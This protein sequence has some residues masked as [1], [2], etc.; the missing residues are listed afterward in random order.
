[1]NSTGQKIR[2]HRTCLTHSSHSIQAFGPFYTVYNHEPRNILLTPSSPV[3]SLL[4]RAR[5]RLSDTRYIRGALLEKDQINVRAPST[6]PY[7]S[8]EIRGNDDAYT[9]MPSRRSKSARPLVNATRQA[10][11]VLYRPIFVHAI[12]HHTLLHRYL[13]LEDHISFAVAA[14]PRLLT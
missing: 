14:S 9:N 8:T 13:L 11:I 6:W 12:P 2:N 4:V 7:G 10:P 5:L 1:M 3:R